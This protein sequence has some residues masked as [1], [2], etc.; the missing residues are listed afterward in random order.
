MGHVTGTFDVPV[1]VSAD[2]GASVF[3]GGEG[4]HDNG[5]TLVNAGQYK[6]VVN[7]AT[8][9]LSNEVIIKYECRLTDERKALLA[10]YGSPIPPDFV[11][12]WTTDLTVIATY[13]FPDDIVT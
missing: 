10:H 6:T 7:F 2:P 9:D 3:I 5:Q 4:N 11:C 8:A 13:I 12:A 1:D